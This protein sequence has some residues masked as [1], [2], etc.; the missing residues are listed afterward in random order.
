MQNN[1]PALCTSEV[2]MFVNTMQDVYLGSMV[3]TE[4]NGWSLQN[5]ELLHIVNQ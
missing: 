3:I 5:I 4:A 2:L 1:N